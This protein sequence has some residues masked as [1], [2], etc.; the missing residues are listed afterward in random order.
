MKKVQLTAND[1]V[2]NYFSKHLKTGKKIIVRTKL[3]NCNTFF[4]CRI[5]YYSIVRKSTFR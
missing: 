2:W 1:N 4:F 3:T 5:V